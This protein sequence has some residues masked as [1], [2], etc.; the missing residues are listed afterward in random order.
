MGEETHTEDLRNV[1]ESDYLSVETTQFGE[2]DVIC[3]DV[4]VQHADPRSGEVRETTIWTLDTPHGVAVTS[5]TEGLKSSPDDPDFPIHNA[6]WNTETEES[7]GF[8]E[9]LHIHGPVVGTA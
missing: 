9:S 3:E 7:M 5:I 6:V 4:E 1:T 2:F 8:I